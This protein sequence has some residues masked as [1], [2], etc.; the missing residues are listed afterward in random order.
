MPEDEGQDPTPE[1]P[2]PEGT[3]ET[4]K[5]EGRT[6]TEAEMGEV[7]REAAGYRTKL[8]DV[9]KRLLQIED[10]RKPELQRLTDQ[11]GRVPTLES[12]VETLKAEL[13]AYRAVFDEQNTRLH[14][15]LEALDKG[16]LDLLVEGL[17]PHQQFAW[18]AKAVAKAQKD[19]EGREKRGAL[20]PAGG[21]NPGSGTEKQGPSEAERQAAAAHYASRF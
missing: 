7:R 10:E 21:R 18:L 2:A 5:P 6:F 4:A 12:E 9:E 19:A 13:D 1:S 11:A 17:S 8:R 16:Q 14:K 15:Q 20:P 3:T